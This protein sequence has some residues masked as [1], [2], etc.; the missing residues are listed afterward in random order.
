MERKDSRHAPFV[1]RV[2]SKTGKEKKEK[3]VEECSGCI[4][5]FQ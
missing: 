1:K 2:R 5:G 4:R 3:E